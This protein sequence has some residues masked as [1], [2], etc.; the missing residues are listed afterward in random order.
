[1]I[2]NKEYCPCCISELIED[3]KQLGNKSIWLVCPKG[4]IRKRP[5]NGYNKYASD[6]VFASTKKR[7]NEVMNKFHEI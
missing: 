4:C 1:M 6:K 2:K 7:V 5:E 3:K